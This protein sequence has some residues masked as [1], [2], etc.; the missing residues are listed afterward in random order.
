MLAILGI[1]FFGGLIVFAV[2]FG[3]IALFGVA[4]GVLKGST[5]ALAALIAI[6]ATVMSAGFSV[7]AV[8]D[9]PKAEDNKSVIVNFMGD[10]VAAKVF[11]GTLP[12]SGMFTD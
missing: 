12:G 2:A 4:L 9:L 1:I 5:K 6:L 7:W 10:E 11:G 8:N 3:L